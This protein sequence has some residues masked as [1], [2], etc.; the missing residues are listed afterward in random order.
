M[1]ERFARFLSRF[2]FFPK[3]KPRIALKTGNQQTS[4]RLKIRDFDPRPK[5]AVLLETLEKATSKELI[6]AKAKIIDLP[7]EYVRDVCAALFQLIASKKL[8]IFESKII[9]RDGSETVGPLSGKNRQIFTDIAGIV[10][11]KGINN[12][13]LEECLRSPRTKNLEYLLELV[14]SV[15]DRRRL[16]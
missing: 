5:K 6:A 2:G 16:P 1:R 9:R 7:E 15:R 13:A 12:H 11:L 3:Q 14:A 4:I 10:L 8:G